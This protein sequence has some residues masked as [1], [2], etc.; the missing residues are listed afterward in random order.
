ML[1][2]KCSICGYIHEGVQCPK[3][4]VRY[5]PELASKEYQEKYLD[6]HS[7]YHKDLFKSGE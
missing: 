2:I 3:C 5:S 6:S 7:T 1:K 4:Q